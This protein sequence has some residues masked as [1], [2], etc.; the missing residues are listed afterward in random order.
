MTV[1]VEDNG[2][3]TPARTDL[4]DLL[5]ERHAELR[6]SYR[7]LEERT[8]LGPDGRPLI[9]R[10]TLENLEK[11]V[12]NQA[13][14]PRLR[15]LEALARAYEL[16][17]QRIRDAAGRQYWGI[18]RIEGETSVG[19]AYLKDADKLTPEQREQI[20]RLIDLF[21]SSGPGVAPG[22]QE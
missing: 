21:A 3:R 7:S 20:Q 11:A 15:E 1:M 19:S 14:T 9:K 6:I 18:D 13:W 4:S 5:R 10:G 2:A 22:D 8:G 16:P 17:L 12:P